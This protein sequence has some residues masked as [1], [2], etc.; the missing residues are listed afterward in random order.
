V[1]KKQFFSAS[2]RF[3]SLRIFASDQSEI[4]SAFFRFVSLIKFFRLA[5]KRNKKKIFRFFSL[6]L[7][8]NFSL[9][10]KAKL[11]ERI[12]A[13]FRFQTFFDPLRFSS[14]LFVS[15]QSEIVSF[16]CP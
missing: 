2:F 12:F 5:S 8:W 9:P 14:D 15:L 11:I 4:N 10:T 3:F 1:K 6:H 13:L 7:V 16:S